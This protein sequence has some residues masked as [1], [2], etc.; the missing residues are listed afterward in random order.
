MM[1]G[2]LLAILVAALLVIIAGVFGALYYAHES[3]TLQQ[4]SL[5]ETPLQAK[6]GRDQGE[7]TF[8]QASK[9]ATESATPVQDPWSTKQ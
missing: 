5:T 8:K 4:R 3:V 7:Q 1:T 9:P 2:K 6:K